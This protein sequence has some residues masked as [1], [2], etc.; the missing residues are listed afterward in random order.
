ME[1]IPL[2]KRQGVQCLGTPTSLVIRLSRKGSRMKPMFEARI[3]QPAVTLCQR[4]SGSLGGEDIWKGQVFVQLT[5]VTVTSG[6]LH[7]GLFQP[8]LCFVFA[9]LDLNFQVLDICDTEGWDLGPLLRLVFNK[10]SFIISPGH[11]NSCLL[12]AENYSVSSL[13]GFCHSNW[14]A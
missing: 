2:S 6:K 11:K 8:C 3:C 4:G 1:K 12:I 5:G 7:T 9:R 13:L 14:R 10:K